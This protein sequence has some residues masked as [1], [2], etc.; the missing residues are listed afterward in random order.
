MEFV[1]LPQF[2]KKLKDF[3]KK[4]PSIKK[5]FEKLLAQLQQYP[6]S[7]TP[8]GKDCFKIRLAIK[9]KAKGKSGGMR[10]ITCVKIEGNS[11]YFL[12]IYDKSEQNNISDKD[13]KVLVDY[14]VQHFRN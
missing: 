7:G 6:R 10:I 1:Y 9:S 3:A 5:D 2:V 4:Y 13:L 12:T 8:L 11:I 14:L